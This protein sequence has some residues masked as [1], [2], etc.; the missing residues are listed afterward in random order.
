[1]KDNKDQHQPIYTTE[2]VG[3]DLYYLTENTSVQTRKIGSSVFKQEK[4][5]WILEYS[6]EIL[7]IISQRIL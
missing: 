4:L 2:L 5:V 1:M 3:V 7:Y 6:C